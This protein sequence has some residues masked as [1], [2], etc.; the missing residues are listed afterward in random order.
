MSRKTEIIDKLQ[1]YADKQSAVQSRLDEIKADA[2]LSAEGKKE[3]REKYVE[4]AAPG[5]QAARD[6]VVWA[7][8]S[9]ADELEGRYRREAASRLADTGYQQ[10]LRSC[11][12]ALRAGAP[13]T[14]YD[15]QAIGDVFG[16]DPVAM[17]TLRAAAPDEKSAALVATVPVQPD[18]R[19]RTV[20]NLRNIANGIK[21]AKDPSTAA[22]TV[23]GNVQYLQDMC[24]DTCEY[25]GEQPA[26]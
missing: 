10:N 13:L 21:E 22:L 2:K 8:E 9:T 16:G 20:N 1:A 11:A 18:Y 5:V 24:G 19:E 17:A 26:E 6:A 23:Q 15:L 7:V 4:E 14:A 12:D 3:A 25:G